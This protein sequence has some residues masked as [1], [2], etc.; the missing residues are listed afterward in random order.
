[1]HC[2]ESTRVD[3]TPMK[4]S[5]SA[6]DQGKASK[7]IL[8]DGL[9]IMFIDTCVLGDI[10]RKALSGDSQYVC[11][12]LACMN[13]RHG[14]FHSIFSERVVKEFNV[15][16]QFIYSEMQNLRNPIQRWNAAVRTYMQMKP[17]L[18][19]DYAEFDLSKA[20]ELYNLILDEIRTLYANAIVLTI[21][22]KAEAWCMKRLLDCKRPAQRG[23]DSLG[24]CIICGSA[25]TFLECVRTQGFVG[26]AFFVSSN[27]K[28]YAMG[29]AIHPEL[30]YEFDRVGLRYFSS[31][32]DAYGAVRNRSD[33]RGK[34]Q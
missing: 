1:M 20:E 23:K 4:T 25:V 13:G 12:A 18:S 33:L 26:D 22:P 34:R 15:P 21:S 28:D 19:S 2:S 27:T 7:I 5:I 31:F 24:D 30:K 10:F 6:L 9:P 8:G 16:G 29:N 32:L 17:E 11:N 3:R 14:R